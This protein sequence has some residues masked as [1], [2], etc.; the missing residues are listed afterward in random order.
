MHNQKITY[1]YVDFGE[2][3]RYRS[4]GNYGFGPFV[5][6]AVFERLVR[7]GVLEPAAI[8]SPKGIDRL[9]KAGTT[10]Q[11]GRIQRFEQKLYRVK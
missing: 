6:F 8:A 1:I 7:D 5:T 4:P 10:F 9:R 11:E 3:R 2:I